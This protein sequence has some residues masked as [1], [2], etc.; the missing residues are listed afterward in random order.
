ME[1]VSQKMPNS[2][3]S[4][5]EINIGDKKINEYKKLNKKIDKII[6]LL[7]KIYEEL[8]IDEPDS[9]DSDDEVFMCE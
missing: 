4:S 9:D 7:E 5:I 3:L 2:K 6:L 1:S 8:C